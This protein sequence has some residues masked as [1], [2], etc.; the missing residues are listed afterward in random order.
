MSLCSHES[1]GRRSTKGTDQSEQHQGRMD[2]R[3]QD[4]LLSSRRLHR[5]RL[6][7]VSGVLCQEIC[8]F[9]AGVSTLS[10]LSADVVVV[11]HFCDFVPSSKSREAREKFRPVALRRHRLQ[12]R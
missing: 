7:D 2:P 8:R 3:V 12:Q 4:C 11:V 1:D 6:D 10:T 5:R 9:E